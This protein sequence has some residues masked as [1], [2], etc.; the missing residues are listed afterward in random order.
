MKSWYLVYCKRA[1]QQRAKLN[2]ENQGV[3][4]YYPETQVEKIVRGK[5]VTKL[6]P[7]FPCYMF[8]RFDV[9]EG[10][11]FTTVRSTRGVVDFVRQGSTPHELQGDL[12]ITLK[13]SASS[14]EVSQQELPKKGDQVRVKSGQFAGIDAIYQEPDGELRSIMLVKML[15]QI[16]PMSIDNKDMEL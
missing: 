11:S 8:I 5:R 2:L 4:C 14:S 13:E 9:N 10:P 15:S 6:E 3:E 12:I 1:E 16:V 7:L